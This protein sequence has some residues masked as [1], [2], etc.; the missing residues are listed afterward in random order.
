MTG[1]PVKDVRHG[2]RKE[3]RSSIAFGLPKAM[4]GQYV[5]PRFSVLT[6]KKAAFRTFPLRIVVYPPI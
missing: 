1:G 6:Q 2:L 3:L 5:W 4:M